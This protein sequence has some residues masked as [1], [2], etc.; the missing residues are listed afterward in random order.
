MH[1]GVLDAADVDRDLARQRALL[2]GA[3]EAELLARLHQ[4]GEHHDRVLLLHHLDEGVGLGAQVL[5]RQ[6]RDLAVAVAAG[7]R[8]E[9]R[10]AALGE[11]DLEAVLA[12]HRQR[13]RRVFLA[14]QVGVVGQQVRQLDAG[15]DAL[16]EDLDVTRQR[17]D[18]RDVEAEG[19]GLADPHLAHRDVERVFRL[20]G[21]G[22][23]RHRAFHQAGVERHQVVERHPGGDAGAHVP[24]RDLVAQ[25]V[26]RV[27]LAD[28]RRVEF[29]EQHVGLRRHQQRHVV[30]DDGAQPR[31]V[32]D[33]HVHR[34]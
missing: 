21:A 7:R 29:L 32:G 28:H 25:H 1:A 26:A 27:G 12:A 30:V 23:R 6:L 4:P 31:A 11:V 14:R 20:D 17:V 5:Q 18:D 8:D 15:D 10:A 22:R 34:R 9:D 2:V 24:E 19:H 13:H 33:D 16:V 3:G